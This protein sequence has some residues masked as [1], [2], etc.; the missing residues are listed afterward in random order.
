MFWP[1]VSNPGLSYSWWTSWGSLV[2]RVEIM[3]PT[4]EGSVGRVTPRCIHLPICT[5]APC[6]PSLGQAAGVFTRGELRL[7]P[8]AGGDQQA[9]SCAGCVGSAQSTL[10]LGKGFSYL[11]KSGR[12]Y[13]RQAA[14]LILW[15]KGLQLELLFCL[16]Q[17]VLHVRFALRGWET[18]SRSSENEEE[19]WSPIVVVSSD[20]EFFFFYL[21]K[22][23]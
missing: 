6:A 23:T 18:W 8:E 13:L 16:S 7:S 19:G 4:L 22:Y 9:D 20:E 12:I 21:I 1:S 3:E 17:E 11:F 15:S 10:L 5:P 2:G 14:Q